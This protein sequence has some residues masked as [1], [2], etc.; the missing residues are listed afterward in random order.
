MFIYYNSLPS[1][2][3]TVLMKYFF[4]LVA[5]CSTFWLSAQNCNLSVDLP[6]EIIV[7][8][9]GET[10]TLMPSITD[11]YDTFTWSPTT[12]LSSSTSLTPSITVTNDVSY[13][14]SVQAVS[15]TELIFNGDFS[16]GDTGFT[17]DYI[18]GTGGGVGLLSNEGQYAIA[19]NA[20]STHN[21]F[22]N[23]NDHTGGGNMMV[24]NASGDASDLWCQEIT[25]S[26]N[27]A[28]SFSA[29]VASVTSQ[30]PAQLQFSVN[31]VQLATPFNASASTCNWQQ[32][33]AEWS[34]DA[35]TTAQICIV[36]TNFT[37]A[38][39]DFALDDISFKE[40]C[41]DTATVAITIA[42]LNADFQIDNSICQNTGLITLNDLLTSSATTGGSW[43][44]DGQAASSFNTE[45]LSIGA[46]TLVY[47]VQT[48]N[49]ALNNSLSFEIVTAPNAGVANDISGCINDVFPI[50][51]F[52]QISGHDMG[53]SWSFVSGPSSGFLN[54]NTGDF[55]NS[56]AGDY[57]FAY[58]VTGS[59]T[60]ADAVT[61]LNISAAATPIAD[62][63]TA[64]TIDCNEASVELSGSNTSS[65]AHISYSWTFNGDPIAGSSASIMADQAGVYTL[66]VT[67]INANCSANASTTVN[68]LVNDI[69]YDLNALMATCLAPDSGR[70]IVQNTAGGTAPYLVSIDGENF[71]AQ[72][73][74]SNLSPGSYTVM[75]QDAAGCHAEQN[76]NLNAPEVPVLSINASSTDPIPLGESV[77][78][79]VASEPSVALLDT[80]IWQPS[81][82]DSLKTADDQWTFQPMQSTTYSLTV[83]DSSGCSASSQITIIVD[84]E[85][86]VFIPNAISP[87]EDGSNDHFS[88]HD[89]GA[90]RNINSLQI[91]NRWGV[92]VYSQKDLKTN[93]PSRMWDAQFNGDKLPQG[94][95]I[96]IMEVEW[97]NGQTEVIEGDV[98]VAY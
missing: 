22:A 72:D 25:V 37:P 67:D 16:Q 7:C 49:C 78:L 15:D 14:I 84:T 64:A 42:D 18:Y 34:S 91:F 48:A 79:S 65:G 71:L 30:N 54:S 39:N 26:P 38:G 19:N 92:Q 74:F 63:P 89:N 35:T 85:T 33:S 55:T 17:S 73:T 87:N 53:G 28:Y 3:K 2:V 36:N 41:T 77:T 75:V 12:G 21:Q 24:V 98:S 47:E 27:T 62:L 31:G 96:Y 45:T 40:I 43:L 1:L 61:Q 57:V 29:W 6:S 52:D 94:V 88:V 58:T 44:L 76:I 20:G 70:I 13:S 46:H 51:L 97:I 60:C 83:I 80:L 66:E 23:C 11:N 59:G 93:D 81:L 95:Y 90:I 50:N 68:S 56:D 69:T 5:I 82:A 9:A 4:S 32:F 8:Q 86:K 10:I